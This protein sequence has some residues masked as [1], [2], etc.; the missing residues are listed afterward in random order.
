MFGIK[1]GATAVKEAP[2]VAPL[3][4][5]KE[6]VRQ[7]AIAHRR[8]LGEMSGRPRVYGGITKEIEEMLREADFAWLV[9]ETFIRRFP[10]AASVRAFAGRGPVFTYPGMKV[11]TYT[12]DIPEAALERMKAGLSVGMKY[13]SI[14]SYQTLP[15]SEEM[16]R[17]DPY[18]VGWFEDPGIQWETWDNP[19]V[20]CPSTLGVIVAAWDLNQESLLPI[21]SS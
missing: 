6:V 8:F 10:Y 14:H 4:I 21:Q 15:I 7:D 9:D 5:Q 2:V 12:G 3:D 19:A 20:A 13:F 18:L 1:T 11:V 16:R 17:V